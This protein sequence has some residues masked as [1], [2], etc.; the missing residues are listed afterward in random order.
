MIK[1]EAVGFLSRIRVRPDDPHGSVS[2]A[3]PLGGD[4]EAQQSLRSSVSL[5]PFPYPFRAAMSICNDAD[6][7][8]PQS[9]RR[10]HQFLSTDEDTVWGPGLSLQVGGSFFMFRSPDSPNEF[11]VFDGLSSTITDDGEFILECARRGLLDV[12]H[13]YGCFTDPTHFT[14]ALAETALDALRSR[15]ITIETWVNHGSS[16]NAQGIGARAEWQGDV[17]GAAAYHADLTI[18]NGVRW[19]W[20]GTE[21]TDRIAL[22]ALHPA[23]KLDLGLRRLKSR[24]QGSV[25]DQ[26]ALTEPYSLRDG[27]CVRRFYRYTGLSGRTPV[28]EDLPSQLSSTNLDELVRAAGYAIVYQHLAVRRRRP[29]FGAEAY[30]PVGDGW[31]APAEL[32]ALRRLAQRHREGEIWVAPTTQLLRYRDI[33]QRV[34]WGPR[35]EADGDVIVIGS[36]AAGPERHQV[37]L[38]DLADLTFY[39]ER[40]ERTRVHFERANRLELVDDVRANPPDATSRPSVTVLPRAKPCSLP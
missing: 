10:L 5:R 4:A 3:I 12:L 19:V 15:G 38:N 20:T 36:R 17:V 11:T 31:F 8:T 30:G 34:D 6:L 28:L 16:T 37:S 21:M 9:F 22:D 32:T 24:I 33:H 40:P 2:N 1:A 26:A 14:R 13:T 23:R 18:E 7:L 29:G 35:R 27:Q 25:D 39:C